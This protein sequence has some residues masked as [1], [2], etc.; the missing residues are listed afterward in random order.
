MD[1]NETPLGE[2]ELYSAYELLRKLT[3]EHEL[4]QLAPLGPT[5][6]YTTLVT[7]WMLTL[8]RLDGGSSLTAV[9]KVVQNYS[10]NLLPN[11]K[12]VREGTLSTGSGAYSEARK[13]LPIK[14][15]ELFASSVCNSLVERSPS[16]FGDQRAYILD[17]TT[18]TLSPT[19][20]LTKVYPPAI[21]QHGIS[22]WPVL[23]MLVA[24]EL[25]SGC[26][27]VPEIGAMYGEGNTSEAKQAAA[28]AKR[29]PAQS[30]V[31]GDAGFGIFSVAHVMIRHGHDILLRLTKQRYKALRRKAELLEETATSTKHRL[32]WIPSD[33]D[34]QRNPHLPA[35]AVLEV[36]I[37]KI[38]REGGDCLML[39]TTLRWSSGEA[40]EAYS[41]RYDVEHNIRDL[42]VT[43]KLEKI[44]AQSE[45]M[46]RKEIL[47]SVVAYNLVLEFR[48]EA[49]KIAK[50][51]PRRL[52][53]TGVWNTFETYLLHQPPCSASKWLERYEQALKI[54]STDKLPNRPDRSYPRKAHSRHPK[55]AKFMKK[56]TKE[57]MTNPEIPDKPPPK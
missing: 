24:H 9:V 21:N 45:E 47:C 35:D 50:I 32:R 26:A 41:H 51:P 20:E 30:I 40:A 56:I 36:I 44:R 55:S 16:W 6:V 8:Q 34:R 3:P 7:L 11:N 27:L 48:R 38:E 13:R 19:S 1:A 12:R 57:K 43:M 2:D 37:H 53:L 28:I 23:M 25:Q 10:K 39:V 31:M 52:S 5:A 29:I 42:K 22:V 17:G 46:V 14:A 18:I 33:N 49:A 54:A 15:A 4:L